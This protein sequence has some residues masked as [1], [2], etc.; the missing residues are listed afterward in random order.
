[1]SSIAEA[2][3]NVRATPYGG[4]PLKI[5]VVA[6]KDAVAYRNKY[7][8]ARQCKHVAACDGHQV[9][10]VTVCDAGKFAKF[11]PFNTLVIRDVI[12]KEKGGKLVI[13]VTKMSKVFMSTQMAIE[14]DKVAEG[15]LLLNPPPAPSVTLKAALASPVKTRCTVT[16]KVVQVSKCCTF[17][18]ITSNFYSFTL[19]QN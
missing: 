5:T 16:G 6:A 4:K 8:E 2:F 18:N 17:A 9:V 12:K 7:G 14:A 11:N 15:H 19:M 13:V 10:K 1:M 3:G